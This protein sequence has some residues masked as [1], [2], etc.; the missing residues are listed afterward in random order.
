MATGLLWL[1]LRNPRKALPWGRPR[2]DGDARR[3]DGRHPGGTDKARSRAW[4]REAASAPS[5]TGAPRPPAAAPLSEGCI[6]EA[7][8]RG[9]ACGRSERPVGLLSPWASGARGRGFTAP[10][11]PAWTFRWWS[12]AQSPS[13]ASQTAG[14]RG[15]SRAHPWRGRRS[16]LRFMGKAWGSEHS[17]HRVRRASAGLTLRTYAP[18]QLAG[19]VSRGE[20]PLLCPSVTRNLSTRPSV[21]PPSPPPTLSLQ[22]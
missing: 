6:T 21:P 7:T 11:C 10:Q 9:E 5:D 17:E 18:G 20:G 3:G 2:S 19:A 14:A 16:S 4:G 22:C 13:V 12:E 1:I 8:S 15:P